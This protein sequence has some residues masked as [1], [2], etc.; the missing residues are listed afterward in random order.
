MTLRAG[1][2][3]AGLM[4]RWH[5][6]AIA[7]LGGAV[8]FVVDTLHDNAQKLAQ[9]YEARAYSDLNQALDENRLDVVHICTPL[10]SHEK[11]A[12]TAIEHGIHIIVEKPFMPN[13]DTT[14]NIIDL[15]RRQNVYA[16]PV[17]Q[18]VHQDGMH[19]LQ[20]NR[21]ALG[22]IQTVHLKFY[23]AGATNSSNPDE[24]VYDILPHPLSILLA[25]FQQLPQVWS[26]YH[27]QAGEWYSTTTV[28][29]M[30]W[31][32]DISMSARPTRAEMFIGGTAGSVNLNFY[33]GYATWQDGSVSRRQKILQ[34][35]QH[36]FS[37]LFTAG[38]NLTKRAFQRETAYPGLRKF[39]HD[40]YSAIDGQKALIMNADDTLW[41]ARVRDL[42]MAVDS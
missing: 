26:V 36:N 8:V 21:D 34:P 4:G 18:F 33:H 14:K 20:N 17:H 15:A 41:I 9:Q 39:I 10:T 19:Q 30:R 31:T 11:L 38:G 13:A 16:I 24:I 23:S 27:P 29:T 35:F 5:A 32:I 37:E 22:K 7:R 1:I 28:N 6:D 25:L 40:C 3:G 42:L 2:I 12:R